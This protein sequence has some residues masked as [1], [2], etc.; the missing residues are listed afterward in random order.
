MIPFRTGNLGVERLRAARQGQP[1]PDPER[2]RAE[3]PRWRALGFDAVED[4]LFW[5][6]VEPQRGRFDW[7]F[8]RG[9]A[10]AAHRAGLQYVVYP[11]VHAAPA[12]Y[13]SRPDFVPGRCLEHGEPGP[14]P[15]PFAASTANN[16]TG[17]Q[18]STSTVL[19]STLASATAR[20]ATPMG[21]SRAPS[22]QLSSAGNFRAAVSGT[23]QY[24]AKHPSTVWPNSSMFWQM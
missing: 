24:S 20:I 7:S 3:M 15:S 23:T 4:Y 17:P 14:M 21:S 1:L 18:P 6:L 22:S 12:W 10:L 13:R 5:E 8:H 11:W 19:P 16:P 2:E 9:N